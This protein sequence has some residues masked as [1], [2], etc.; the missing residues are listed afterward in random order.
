MRIAFVS[1]ILDYPHGGA[2]TLWTHA[3]TAAGAR[4]DALLVAVSEAVAAHESVAAIPAQLHVR[5]RPAV[6]VSLRERAAGRLRRMLGR[7]DALFGAIRRFRPDLLVISLGGTYDLISMPGWCEWLAGTS[8]PL[9]FI[10]NCQDERPVLSDG[11]KERA[12]RLFRR[13]EQICFVST[14]NLEVTRAHLGASIPNATIIQNPLR[15]RPEDVAPWPE[16]GVFSIASVSRLEEVKGVHL[17]LRAAAAAIAAE[18]GWRIR[19][20]GRGPDEGPL[21]RLAGELGLGAR[22]EFPGYVRELRSIWAENH[23]LA[24]P[25]VEDGVPMTIPEAMLCARPVL[26]TAVGGARDWISDGAS[27]FICPEP[28]ADALG[29]SLRRAWD[30]RLQWREMGERAARD[31]AARYA[32]QD[33]MRLIQPCA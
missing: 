31:A 19:V 33:Y 21:R 24:S 32:P 22:I 25:A 29:E 13:C 6:P 5:R 12:R 10:A 28:S 3:A 9:R 18:G 11:D 30:S 4:G 1:T 15:W 8:T 16:P 2:D 26:S 20:Y 14:R 7:G 27:G 17:L 23:L